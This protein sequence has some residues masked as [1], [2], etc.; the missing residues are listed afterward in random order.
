MTRTY[1]TLIERVDGV[2]YPQ[3]GDYRLSV[4]RH[5][6]VDIRNADGAIGRQ[7]RIV[8]SG[9]DQASIDNAI[10]NMNERN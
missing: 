2:W 9:D 1:Y 3:F 8:T 5:E 6:L 4:V 10:A 7:F